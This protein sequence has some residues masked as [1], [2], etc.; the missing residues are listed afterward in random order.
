MMMKLKHMKYKIN[1]TVM[2]GSLVDLTWTNPIFYE[3]TFKSTD[4]YTCDIAIAIS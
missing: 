1:E 2:H 3:I 4:M